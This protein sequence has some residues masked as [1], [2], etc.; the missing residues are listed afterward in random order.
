[1][2]RLPS[3]ALACFIDRCLNVRHTLLSHQPLLRRIQCTMLPLLELVQTLQKHSNGTPLPDFTQVSSF[4]SIVYR[5]RHYI[6]Q[7]CLRRRR[8][9]RAPRSLP[10]DL[11]DII[12]R[13]N[14][15]SEVQVHV[16]WISIGGL[17]LANSQLASVT[18]HEEDLSL[19]P[20][21]ISHGIGTLYR[22]T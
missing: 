21:A 12:S 3:Q 10:S 5:L 2:C 9:K 19:I 14:G 8:D 11:V 4:C 16:L 22:S 17:A 18:T 1:M 15:L 6:F 20:L 7:H 13:H